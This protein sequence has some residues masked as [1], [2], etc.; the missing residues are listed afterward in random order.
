MSSASLSALCVT[1]AGAT[2]KKSTATNMV[3]GAGH[4]RKHLSSKNGCAHG[5]NRLFSNGKKNG[6]YVAESRDEFEDTPFHAAVMTYLAYFFYIIFGYFRDFLRKHGLEKC[7]TVK[8][9]GNEVRNNF[10]KGW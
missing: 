4:A 5:S 2:S 8:E 7:K 9:N 3:S 1:L 10:N 6:N